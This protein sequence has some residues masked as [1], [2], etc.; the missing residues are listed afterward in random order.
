MN[1]VQSFFNQKPELLPLYETLES[2]ICAEFDDV[3]IKV[4]KTQISFYNKHM[5]A[6]VSLPLRRRKGWPDECLVFTL[7]LNRKLEHPRVAY[8]VEPYPGRWTHHIL[9]QTAGE[10]D[11]ELIEWI[12]EAYAFAMIK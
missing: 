12:R 8:A 11:A 7:G 1:E 2:V 9:I 5:F 3:R 6:C 4:Q 10:V